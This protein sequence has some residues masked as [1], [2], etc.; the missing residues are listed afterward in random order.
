M[1]FSF[2]PKLRFDCII[3][4]TE[5]RGNLFS[6]TRCRAGGSNRKPSKAN[7]FEGQIVVFSGYDLIPIQKADSGAGDADAQQD[8]RR[9]QIDLSQYGKDHN[10]D[11]HRQTYGFGD[12]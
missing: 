8:D 7:A 6:S 12:E 2:C 3:A 4:Q 5:K 10:G 9:V 1:I 11:A